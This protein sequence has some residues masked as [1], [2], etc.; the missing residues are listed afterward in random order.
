MDVVDGRQKAPAAIHLRIVL[1]DF[2]HDQENGR[3]GES[4]GQRADERVC[5]DI[6]ALPRVKV[7]ACLEDLLR[8][9][10]ELVDEGPY[11]LGEVCTVCERLHDGQRQTG[12]WD[13]HCCAVNR[14]AGLFAE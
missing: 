9:A 1:V 10:V 3:Y 11:C 6:Q 4:E 2:R 14:N 8:Q 7:Q 13:D 5:R 12:C